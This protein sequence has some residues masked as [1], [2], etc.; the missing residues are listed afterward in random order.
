MRVIISDMLVLSDNFI[1]DMREVPDD[2]VPDASTPGNDVRVMRGGTGGWVR[3]KDGRWVEDPHGATST[4]ETRPAGAPRHD[5]PSILFGRAIPS[6]YNTLNDLY[7][8]RSSE[9]GIDGSAM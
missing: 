5:G 7:D 3:L 1:L 4:S 9:A 6:P 8:P 2:W